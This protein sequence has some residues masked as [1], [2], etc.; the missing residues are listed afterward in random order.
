MPSSALEGA[1]SD[2]EL[3]DAGHE[4]LVAH[5]LFEAESVLKNHTFDC[6]LSDM[7]MGDGTGAELLTKLRA[8]G[9]ETPFLIMTGFMDYKKEDL[10]E[11]GAYDLIRKPFQLDALKSLVQ[12][13]AM[14]K[15][16]S[17][18]GAA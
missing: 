12:S 18:S 5:S 10:Q 11:M 6:I 17:S 16:K 15:E 13:A 9:D 14:S 7:R 8:S 4:G 2:W 1:A 3:E